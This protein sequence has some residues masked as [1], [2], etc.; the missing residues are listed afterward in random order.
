MRS[1]DVVACAS[2]DVLCWIQAKRLY[3]LFV[4]QAAELKVHQTLISGQQSNSHKISNIQKPGCSIYQRYNGQSEIEKRR[5]YVKFAQ[6]KGILI[7]A[8]KQHRRQRNRLGNH[9]S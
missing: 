8:T 9:D 3:N 5:E 4:S 1:C 2:C 6:K 7:D